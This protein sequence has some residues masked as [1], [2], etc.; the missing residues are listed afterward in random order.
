M[1]TSE[2]EAPLTTLNAAVENGML[3][4]K[5]EATFVSHIW[6]KAYDIPAAA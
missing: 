3:R 4:H 6:F 1:L 2:E 5:E